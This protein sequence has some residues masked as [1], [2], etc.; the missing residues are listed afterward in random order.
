MVEFGLLTLSQVPDGQRPW[1][2]IVDD[3]PAVRDAVKYLVQS[4]GWNVEAFDS[5]EA[6][7]GAYTPERRG[8]LVLDL[9]MPNMNGVELQRRLA[10]QNIHIP[11]IVVTAHQDDPLVAQAKRA[12]ALSIL[13]KP[14]KDRDLACGI[15]QALAGL[16]NP[17]SQ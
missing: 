7:L 6:F 12:G 4:F 10:A 1:V 15:V 9:H 13:A 16:D 2:F 11:V 17:P 5:A 3:D 8:C 14:F